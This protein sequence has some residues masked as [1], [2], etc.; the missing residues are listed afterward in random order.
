[1]LAVRLFADLERGMGLA[2][3]AAAGG[4]GTAVL[5]EA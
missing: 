4:I 3:I 1:V 2:A 5:L